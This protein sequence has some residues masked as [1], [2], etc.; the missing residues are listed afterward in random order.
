MLHDLDSSIGELLDHVQALGI[1]DNTYIFFMADNGAT[2]FLPPV[3]N[4]LDPPGVF[5]MPMRNFPLRGGKWTLYEGGIRVPMIVAGPGV[6]ANSQCDV[7]VVGWD[8]LATFSALAGKAVL[9][10]VSDGGSFEPLLKHEGK[11][12]VQRNTPGLFFHRYND[13]Y[14]HSAY[15]TGDYKVITFWKTGKVELYDLSHDAG[16]LHDLASSNP[17][18][19]TA[20]VKELTDYMDRVHP[21]LTSSYK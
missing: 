4:R 2:E 15:V 20:M 9:P 21:G 13:H 6:K 7:P 3:K 1:A 12:P 16:E 14:P 5:N 11:G 10:G 19:A 17:R 18:K 8:L